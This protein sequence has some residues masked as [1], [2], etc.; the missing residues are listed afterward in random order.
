MRRARVQPKFLEAMKLFGEVRSEPTEKS[1]E[2]RILEGALPMDKDIER[3]L[4]KVARAGQ[5]ERTA[6]QAKPAAKSKPKRD[7]GPPMLAGRYP[8]HGKVK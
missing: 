3:V 6:Q 1:P 7:A 4:M 8:I 5:G 2:G